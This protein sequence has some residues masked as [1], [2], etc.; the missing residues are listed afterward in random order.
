MGI[1]VVI[2]ALSAR[3]MRVARSEMFALSPLIQ[4]ARCQDLISKN[5]ENRCDIIISMSGFVSDK[6]VHF[7][8]GQQ[9]STGVTWVY[10]T[11]FG[12]PFLCRRGIAHETILFLS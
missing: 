1:C 7:V 5:A 9:F 8:D 10:L 4:F 2:F 6:F 3:D 12:S 11:H